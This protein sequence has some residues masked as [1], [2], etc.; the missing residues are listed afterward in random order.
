MD[1]QHLLASI[2]GTVAQDLRRNADLVTENRLLRHQS[3][4]RVRL[5]DGER[6]TL[7]EI[8]PKLGQHAL[9]DVAT[10][11]PPAPSLAW[12]RKLIAQQF[13]GA[14]PRRSPGRPS[15]AAELEAWLV[16][17]APEHR[18]W[19]YDRSGGAL[20]QGGYTVS[21]QTLGNMLK[22]PGSPPAPER[23]TPTPWKECIRTPLAVLMATAFC[24]AAVW[25]LGGLATYDVLLFSRLGPR[26]GPVA[27]V[28]PH[29]HQAWMRQV[30]RN[31]TMQ[32]WGWWS[33]GPSLIHD[34]DGTSCPALH[35]RS[36]AAGVTRV[37]LPPR[38]PHLHASAER[39]GR[40]V[41][42]ECLARCMRFGEGSLSHILQ[43]DVAHVPQER[44]HQ[45]QGHMLLRPSPAQ[46][47]A[48]RGPL[49][50]VANGWAACCNT[51]SVTRPNVC[52]PGG[53]SER[54][55][56]GSSLLGR[57][58]KTPEAVGAMQREAGDGVRTRAGLSASRGALLGTRVGGP[59]RH[60]RL[61]C[62]LSRRP[63]CLRAVGDAPARMAPQ[64]CP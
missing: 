61:L 57:A 44:P 39:W 33:P 54:P 2:T 62:A 34:R 11:V 22:R 55:R 8:G 6:K 32:A 50:S 51:M 1:W 26:E 3:P 63:L 25:P 16:R 43:E 56:G 49:S 5:T 20:A 60:P 15:I 29:P 47:P 23:Q 40:S 64:R 41:Q 38:A 42:E 53:T 18:S 14:P 27:G 36:D 45:G 24:T 10:I 58:Q 7:A 28:T 9:A 52:A 30:A 59:G 35:Q 13:A 4:G 17:L 21:A 31:L 19:G 12:P 48:R 37:P 46:A